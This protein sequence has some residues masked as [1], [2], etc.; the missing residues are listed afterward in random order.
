MLEEPEQRRRRG[1]EPFACLLLVEACERRLDGAP[2]VLDERVELG[3]LVA[4]QHIERAHQLLPSHALSGE[5]IRSMP[6][7]SSTRTTGSRGS[8]AERSAPSDPRLR[9][10][11]ASGFQ[12]VPL[13]ADHA[14][15][16]GEVDRAGFSAD[17][18]HVSVAD[19]CQLSLQGEV[20]ETRFPVLPP[21]RKPC[22]PTEPSTSRERPSHR[23]TIHP[24][25]GSQ[26]VS[27]CSSSL[28]G[29]PGRVSLPWRRSPRM[30]RFVPSPSAMSTHPGP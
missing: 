3:A 11:R 8:E 15:A 1:H 5:D 6:A 29:F 25:Q 19:Q 24:R 20:R 22:A 16:R 4:Q 26:S 7:P 10:V 21:W 23:A 30:E 14:P 9:E 27:S 2:V 12:C 13:D 28:L 17:A 18:L